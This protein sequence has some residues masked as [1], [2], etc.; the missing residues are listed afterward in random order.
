MGDMD[1]MDIAASSAE[2]RICCV[3]SLSYSYILGMPNI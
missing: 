1:F 2:I 3:V